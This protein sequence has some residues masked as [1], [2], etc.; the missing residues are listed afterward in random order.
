[1]TDIL[2][3][4]GLLNAP[5]ICGEQSLKT[6]VLGAFTFSLFQ[7]T[8]ILTASRSR[9]M[10]I[11]V[12][13]KILL[14]TNRPDI[15]QV[16]KFAF[17]LIISKAFFD[18]DIWA[19]LI[20]LACQDVPFLVVRLCVLGWFWNATF[21]TLAFIAKNALVILVQS[22]RCILMLHVSPKWFV[23]HRVSVLLNDRYRNP[24]VS[25]RSLLDEKRQSMALPS[26]MSLSLSQQQQQQQQP[27]KSSRAFLPVKETSM[28]AI[29][30]N[31]SNG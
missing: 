5:A 4:L 28:C 16:K 22:Y 8:L 29:G 31:S 23:L 27:H 20:S 30:G 18:L 21:G 11:A 10:R 17:L 12:A 1:M 13:T 9:K 14:S 7:F 15:R 2:E 26:G 3:F 19:I 6:A 25:A 24:E